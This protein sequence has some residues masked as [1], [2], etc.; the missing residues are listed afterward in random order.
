MGLRPAVVI[1]KKTNGSGDE[2]WRIFDSSRGPINVNNKHLIPSSD[3]A[4]STET[5]MD[6]LSNGFKLRHADAHQNQDGTTY[7]YAAWAEAPTFNLYGAQSN[8]R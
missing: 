8:A 2:N 5:G 4:E 7:I 6:F 3:V 1:L